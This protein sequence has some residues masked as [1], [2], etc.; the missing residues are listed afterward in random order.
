[1][2]PGVRTPPHRDAA[3]SSQRGEPPA[4]SPSPPGPAGGLP[5]AASPGRQGTIPAPGRRGAGSGPLD[6]PS[7]HWQPPRS[8]PR[9][10]LAPNGPQ[11]SKEPGALSRRRGPCPGAPAAYWQPS[12]HSSSGSHATSRSSASLNATSRL[13]LVRSPRPRKFGADPRGS[14]LAWATVTGLTVSTV[15]LVLEY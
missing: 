10:D 1:M 13:L 15:I 8:P 12:L 14:L 3:G 5:L 2:S 6:S 4:V 11:P 9:H 7:G